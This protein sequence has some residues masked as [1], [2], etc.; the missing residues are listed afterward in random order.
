MDYLPFPARLE[1]A[2]VC[3]TGRAVISGSEDALD[4]TGEFVPLLPLG[5]AAT[6]Q[7]RVGDSPVQNYSGRVYLSSPEVL[8]LVGLPA[9]PVRETRAI[10]ASN[11]RLAASVEAPGG[12]GRLPVEIVYLSRSALTLRTTGLFEGATRLRLHCEVDFLT[13]RRMPL[14]VEHQILLR[15]GEALLLCRAGNIGNE[16]L[17]ALS[18]YAARLE[19]LPEKA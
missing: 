12:A 14:E 8:R 17:I 5:A 6:V 1:A 18:A 7:W 9:G 10:F 3:E 4:F 16:N 13:L 11:I 19:H 15:A 2:G